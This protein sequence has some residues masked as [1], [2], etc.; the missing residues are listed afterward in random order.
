MKKIALFLILFISCHMVFA[1]APN[2]SVSEN[3]YQYSM[4]IVARLNVGGKQLTGANDKVAAF[5]GNVCRGVSGVTYVASEKK[6][7]AYL[8]IFANQ[9][10][11]SI[12][13]RLYDSSTDRATTVSKQIVFVVNEHKGNLF[14][15]YSIAEPALNHMAEMLSFNFFDV[16]S[17]TSIISN[18][19]AKINISESYNTKAL[20][21]VFTL[22]AGA[23]LFK[24]RI[25]QKSGEVTDDFSS[26][27]TYE[28]LS[29]D[30]SALKTYKVSVNQSADPTLF[31]KKDAVCYAKGAIKVV[32]KRE[33]SLVQI[34]SNGKTVSSKQIV[35]GQAIFADLS[36]GSYIA[37]LGNEWKIVNIALKTK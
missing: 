10:G 32:S 15:S 30:E 6:Y 22:S 29:E 17:L 37:T 20:K 16:K 12:A 8:T 35:N 19:S 5:V 3:D 24:N 7:Y 23:S 1:Q 13:F 9:Q 11:E 27:V 34:T 28:V 33:G 14:Q 36:E 31:Y 25:L 2:W 26:E 4:T 18:G 21:P